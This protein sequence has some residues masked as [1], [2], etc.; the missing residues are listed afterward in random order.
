MSDEIKVHCT[1]KGKDIVGHILN[2][3]SGTFLEVAINTVKVKFQYEAQF[4]QYVGNMA[5]LEWVV[6]QEDLP[7]DRG[8]FR[9]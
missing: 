9:R 2:Y 5:G 8:E 7:N 3:R 4:D 6:K 1:D